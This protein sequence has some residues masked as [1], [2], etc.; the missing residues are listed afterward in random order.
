MSTL[1][2]PSPK[3]ISLISREVDF[4]ERIIGSNL[5]ERAGVKTISLYSLHEL[6]MLLNK[7]YPQIDLNKMESWIRTVIK[8][9]ELAARIKTIREQPGSEFDRLLQ[10][11][12]LV[13]L[14]LLQCRTENG[15]ISEKDT[16]KRQ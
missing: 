16:I 3:L 7:P 12:N 4:K 10:I 11:R 15:N 8:D 14:R 1:S 5:H 13:G 6:Y 2:A 9:E